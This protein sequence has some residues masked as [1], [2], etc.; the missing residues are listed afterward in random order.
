VPVTVVFVYEPLSSDGTRF[1]PRIEA[2]PG[3]FFGLVGPVLKGAI[4]R[5]LKTD[6]EMLKELLERREAGR[7]PVGEE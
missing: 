6:L 4:R 7:E 2:E 1:T 5:Q 3:S